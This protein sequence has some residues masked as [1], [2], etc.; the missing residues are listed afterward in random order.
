MGSDIKEAHEILQNTPKLMYYPLLSKDKR[1][2]DN[3]AEIDKRPYLK[4]LLKKIDIVK[5]TKNK[6][7]KMVD[8]EYSMKKFKV[9]RYAI[10]KKLRGF[11]INLLKEKEVI[12]N[13]SR[14]AI[15]LITI[16]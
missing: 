5:E 7:D 12:Q 6:R 11:L 2:I 9:E 3:E 15:I 1:Y 16:F 13:I 4:N 10:V 14:E 8:D